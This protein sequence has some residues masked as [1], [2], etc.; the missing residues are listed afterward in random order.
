MNEA[1]DTAINLPAILLL[2]FWWAFLTF[3]DTVTRKTDAEDAKQSALA[4][5]NVNLAHSLDDER[6]GEIGRLDPSFDPNA[7][8]DGARR[9]YEII[10]EAF[11]AAD[12]ETLKPLLSRE[13]MV[14]FESACAERAERGESVELT[15]IGIDT[16]DVVRA[17]VNSESME[18]TLR[19]HTQ[20]VWVE[21]NA[22]GTIVG[23]DPAEVADMVDTWTFARP[24]PVSSNTWAVV[25]TGQ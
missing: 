21:R 9:A 14:A 13:V 22:E 18:V 8:L 12:I 7:F 1:A 11:A 23:G 15:L 3:V 5:S 20:M 19:F 17:N 24:V 2:W 10:V 25:A 6:F 16:V 4:E